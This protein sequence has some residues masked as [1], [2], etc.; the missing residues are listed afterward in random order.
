VMT[1]TRADRL[2]PDAYP[3]ELT[4]VEALRLQGLGLL[5]GAAVFSAAGRRARVGAAFG[6]LASALGWCASRWPHLSRAIEL[7]GGIF[8]GPFIAALLAAAFAA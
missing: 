4:A 2:F 1:W 8:A 6:L 7:D 3:A 5:L